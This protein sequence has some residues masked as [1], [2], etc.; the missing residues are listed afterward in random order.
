MKLAVVYDNGEIFQH[1]GHANEFK[2]YSI[3]NG[4][5]VATEMLSAGGAH[6]HDAMASVLVE[7]GVEVLICGGMG[8]GAQSALSAGGVMVFSGAQGDADAAVASY[9]VGTLTSEGVNCDHHSHNEGEGCG[10][11]HHDEEEEGCGCG[12]GSDE[13]SSCGCGGCGGCGSHEMTVIYEGKNAGKAVK[14]HYTGTFDDGEKFDS[15]YDRG[16]PLEFIAGVG[17]MIPGFDKTVVEMEVGEKRSIHLEPQDA[18]GERDPQALIV[19]DI[20]DMPGSENLEVDQRIVLEDGMGRQFPVVVMAKND[21][22]VTFDA[23][24]Q[25][26]GKAL[27]FDIELVEVAE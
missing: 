16:E 14:A 18:Y 12:C 23:N 27:N 26:A 8:A 17:M 13:D 3:E 4:E 6:G 2:I 15:S 25:M 9:L 21:K 24:H 20:E 11:G 19:I 5:I 22:T 1:F 7:N 10:C